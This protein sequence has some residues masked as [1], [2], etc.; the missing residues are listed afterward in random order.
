MFES[1]SIS[2][3]LWRPA[4]TRSS[5]PVP[6]AVRLS[7]AGL[8][9][10]VLTAA[11]NSPGQTAPTYPELFREPLPNLRLTPAD[12]PNLGRLVSLEATSMFIHARDELY[13]SP[14][15]TR[16]LE[17]IGALWVAADAFTA[18]VSFDSVDARRVEAGLLAY[19]TCGG[20]RPASRER[21]YG[22]RAA[23]S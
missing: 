17:D 16:L 9:L 1:N 13:D 19:P 10:I 12:L 3:P 4:D 22:S 18:A 14:A 15:G 6:A 11:P 20:L 21:G 8:L 2:H 23:R 5:R 7:I